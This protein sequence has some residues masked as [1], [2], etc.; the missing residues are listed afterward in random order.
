[1]KT[2]VRTFVNLRQY[3]KIFFRNVVSI[4]YIDV[5]IIYIYVYIYIHTYRDNTG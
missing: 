4:Y 2:F 5:D 1:M 3:V